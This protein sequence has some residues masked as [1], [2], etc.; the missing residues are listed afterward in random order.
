[1]NIIFPLRRFNL[2]GNIMG[3][4]SILLG[5]LPLPTLPKLTISG[6]TRDSTGTILGGCVV[7]LLRTQYDVKVDSTISD[8]VTGAYEFS[9]VGLGQQYYIVAYK[10][11][12]PDVAGT[13]RNDIIGI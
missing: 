6:I 1:M 3:I 7:E 2:Y 4:P 5:I 12:S 13:T 11:G 10:S 9:V 8:A